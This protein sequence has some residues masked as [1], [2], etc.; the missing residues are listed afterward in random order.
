MSQVIAMTR[1]EVIAIGWSGDA[2]LLDLRSNTEYTIRGSA[3]VNYNHTDYQTKTKADTAIK[4]AAN[5]GKWNWNPRPVILKLKGNLIAASTHTFP[6]SIPVASPADNIVSPPLTRENEKN[7]DGDY[8]L[9]SH[10]CLHYIDSITDRDATPGDGTW[11]DKMYQTVLEAQ[12]L[13]TN[14]LGGTPADP[15]SPIL[16]KG[17]SGDK[18]TELQELLN[19]HGANPPLDV[20]GAFGPLTKAAVEEFQRKNALPVTGI[21]NGD[22]WAKLR[23]GQAVSAQGN[24][25]NTNEVTIKVQQPLPKLGANIIN[26]CIAGIP[27]AL[28]LALKFGGTGLTEATAIRGQVGAAKALATIP[29]YKTA[30]LNGLVPAPF[31]KMVT[32]AILAQSSIFLL[33]KFQSQILDLISGGIPAFVTLPDG[34]ILQAVVVNG[35]TRILFSGERPPVNA[36]VEIPSSGKKFLV[37]SNPNVVGKVS[38][39][40]ISPATVK[41]PDGTVKPATIVN[42]I[43]RVG[44]NYSPDNPRPPAGAIVELPGSDVKYLAVSDPDGRIFGARIY[45]ATARMSPD[46]PEVPATFVNGVTRIGEN[47]SPANPRPPVGTIVDI[48]ALNQKYSIVANP[49]GEGGVSEESVKPPEPRPEPE[50]KPEPEPQSDA[51]LNNFENASLQS[52][53]EE[54]VK[55][56]IT[57]FGYTE[58]DSVK[59]IFDKPD[60]HSHDG[61]SNYTKYGQWWQDE[62]NGVSNGNAWCV[63]FTAWCANEAKITSTEIPFDASTS[64][65]RGKFNGLGRLGIPAKG[66]TP[67]AGDFVFYQ[68]HKWN[69]KENKWVQGGHTGIVIGYDAS[70]GFVYTIEGNTSGSVGVRVDYKKFHLASLK[71]DSV[72][73]TISFGI[74]GGGA[75]DRYPSGA[76]NSTQYRLE[77][78]RPYSLSNWPSSWSVNKK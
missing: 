63:I 16:L 53:I 36:I 24:K 15:N 26:A 21:V 45:P 11:T 13:G 57:Q 74:N 76:A 48:P 52:K 5:N 28:L 2:E 40:E 7:D 19:S 14:M 58:K 37:V 27:T 18:V 59:W 8:I 4:L 70:S 69:S 3:P 54:M 66:Y 71:N 65:L 73:A 9:G 6:H 43:T 35:I 30:I 72:G 38:G 32:G 46:G 25:A 22:T 10:F 44:E 62:M 68:F 64:S 55:I 23:S 39:V 67:Q 77:S 47:Y 31:G 50:P 12:A 42:G 51:Q 33:P 34:T 56:A 60:D 20:D 29:T 61:T 78:N 1:D 75:T 41:M 49:E 17:I